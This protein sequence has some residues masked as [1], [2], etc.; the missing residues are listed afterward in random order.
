MMPGVTKSLGDLRKMA[1]MAKAA[2]AMP[3]VVLTISASSTNSRAYRAY[4]AYSKRRPRQ[5]FLPAKSIG[6]ALIP[7]PEAGKS[8]LQGKSRQNLRTSATKARKAG[9]RVESFNQLEFLEDILAIH[10]SETSRQGRTMDGDYLDRAA[11]SEVARSTELH[12]FGVFLED[13]LVGYCLL[14]DLGETLSISRIIGHSGHLADGIMYAL[15]V[16]LLERFDRNEA[17]F[18]ATSNWFMYDT[19]LGA[20]DGLRTFKR[21]VGFAPYRVNWVW[22]LTREG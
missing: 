4:V 3:K 13:Q 6:V 22:R 16:E 11:V 17:P 12:A 10:H 14:D 15:M 9:Y 7:R 1:A 5:L 8:L 18:S 2:R 21:N 19:W 20:S